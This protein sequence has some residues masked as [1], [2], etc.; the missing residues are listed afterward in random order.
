MKLKLWQQIVVA[1]ILGIIVGL[2]LTNYKDSAIIGY[3]KSLG[4]FFFKLIKMLIVP[5]IFISLVVG[6][7]SIICTNLV[8]IVREI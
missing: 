1:L 7:T 8:D 4:D 6:M 5:L 2:I 3:L